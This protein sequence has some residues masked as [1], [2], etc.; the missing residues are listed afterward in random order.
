MKH[1]NKLLESTRWVIMGEFKQLLFLSLKKLQKYDLSKQAHYSD[2]RNGV[3]GSDYKTK[4]G[5]KINLKVL[6][7]KLEVRTK[8]STGR[9]AA[10]DATKVEQMW[11]TKSSR[12]TV[13]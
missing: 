13:D 1:S 4:E 2:K 10:L 5:D 6:R 3:Q 9:K 12:E 11:L 8:G 7:G